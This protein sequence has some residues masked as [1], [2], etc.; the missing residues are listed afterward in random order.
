VTAGSLE[1]SLLDTGV[2]RVLRLVAQSAPTRAATPPEPAYD[3]H[4][5]LARRAATESAVLLKN[6]GV[7]P[8]SL[9]A[10]ETLAVIGAFA[11][12]PRYQGA[13]SSQVNPTRIDVPLDELRAALPAGVELVHSPGFSLEDPTDEAADTAVRTEA[14]EIAR[15]ADAVVLFLGL[16]ASAESEGFDRTHLDLPD[17]QLALLA[18][19]AEVS[20]R[21]VVVLAN[22]SVVRT[23]TWEDR[24]GG[25]LEC[26]LGGQA[27][28]GA[29]ADLVTG[30]ANPSGKLAE[31]IPVRLEDNPSY[32]NFP[33][34]SQ[35]VR[36]G[37]GLF[38][39]YRAY[40]ATALEV[41]H[42]FGFGLSYTTFEV[43]APEVSVTGSV[44]GG[45]LLVEVTA[46]VTNTGQRAGAE[47]VQVYVTDPESSVTRPR[48]ELKGFAKIALEPGDSGVVRMTLDDRAFSFWSITWGRWVVEAGE[49]VLRL[50]TSS[51]DLPHTYSL[52]LDAP[53]IAAPLTRDS[54]LYEWLADPR[55]GELLTR[56]AAGATTG[57]L[58]DPGLLQVVGT[59]PLS[60]IVGFGMAGLDHATLDRLVDALP[61]R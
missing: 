42:P 37:E 15:D 3:A 6:D 39:G 14:R 44:S 9:T 1:E 21:V 29:V 7:L 4:H 40:D 41:S 34:D 27:A 43:G 12:E 5:A 2:R 58:A 8:L 59:M 53:S 35:V 46:T 22:G 56:A 24:V 31:T 23:S 13:G 60:T 11:T 25:M 38:I 54:T 32:L 20:N 26:W 61:D 47:V 45:D 55:G 28:G 18:T 57:P 16:P 50:G 48:Q 51:R 33:G 49:F 36:Y 30:A 17:N 52:Q 19:V 10:G